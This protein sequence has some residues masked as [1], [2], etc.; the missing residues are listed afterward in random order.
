MSCL[1]YIYIPS[2]FWAGRLKGDMKWGSPCGWAPPHCT[3]KGVSLNASFLSL[4]SKATVAFEIRNRAGWFYVFSSA[5]ILFLKSFVGW[6]SPPVTPNIIPQA[7]M[8]PEKV[9]W[10]NATSWKAASISPTPSDFHNE[11]VPPKF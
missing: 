4:R 5:F 1:I 2:G 11:S 6:G 9:E 10:T 7:Y 3:I 8:V